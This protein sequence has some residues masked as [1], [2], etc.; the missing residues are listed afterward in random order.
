LHPDSLH[1]GS[2][3]QAPLQLKHPVTGILGVQGND[4]Q[5]GLERLHPNRSNLRSQTPDIYRRSYAGDHPVGQQVCFARLPFGSNPP[6][7][8]VAGQYGTS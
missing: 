6:A 7:A 4:A 3:T 5:L 8:D 1:V 2:P